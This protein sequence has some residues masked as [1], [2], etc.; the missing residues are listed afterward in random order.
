MVKR[1]IIPNDLWHFVGD[2]L[3]ERGYINR[4]AILCAKEV[5]KIRWEILGKEEW[6]AYSCLDMFNPNGLNSKEE[7]TCEETVSINLYVA[8]TLRRKKLL[9]KF[10]ETKRLIVE[11]GFINFDNVVLMSENRTEDLFKEFNQKS[12]NFLGQPLIFSLD[13]ARLAIF[14]LELIHIYQFMVGKNFTGKILNDGILENQ[15]LL[16]YLRAYSVASKNF[17]LESMVISKKR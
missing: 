14:I 11:R 17:E 7:K 2:E 8:E 16:S 12:I 9:K 5:P 15:I 13:S 10:P 3:F 6:Q 1:I 4:N